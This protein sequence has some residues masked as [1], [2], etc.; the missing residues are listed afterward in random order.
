MSDV[1]LLFFGLGHPDQGKAPDKIYK[2]GKYER[3]QAIIYV[4]TYKIF[5]KNIFKIANYVHYLHGQSQL[6]GLL[7]HDEL[8]QVAN[9]C[10]VRI[11]SDSMIIVFTVMIALQ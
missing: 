11:R 8:T 2:V 5:K 7:K 9:C 6:A 3:N 10:L 4:R 1:S